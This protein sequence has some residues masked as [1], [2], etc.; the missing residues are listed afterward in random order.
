GIGYYG[1]I[2]GEKNF[3]NDAVNFRAWIRSTLFQDTLTQV[4]Y[5]NFGSSSRNENSISAIK[6]ADSTFFFR[7]GALRIFLVFT[8]CPI[9]PSSQTNYS[10]QWAIPALRGKASV[11]TIFTGDT[12][13][14]T[15][16]WYPYNLSNQNPKDLS[17]STGGTYKLLP[18]SGRGLL[19]KELPL[20]DILVNSYTIDFLT[21]S[22]KKNVKVVFKLNPSL[23]GESNYHVDFP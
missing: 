12:T 6:F 9:K 5:P 8:D 7:T 19:L 22:G 20:V 3:T 15:N 17:H 16:L 11:H 13:A 23:D 2:R 14:F 21:S 1:D 18:S 4:L 10:L